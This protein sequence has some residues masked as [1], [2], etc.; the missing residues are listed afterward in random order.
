MLKLTSAN[1]P[2]LHPEY[3]HL[4]CYLIALAGSSVINRSPGLF[5]FIYRNT[6]LHTIMVSEAEC[7]QTWD[8]CSEN[9]MI[10][11]EKIFQATRL[12]EQPSRDF[13]K[14]HRSRHPEVFFK[15]A[16]RKNYE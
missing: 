7:K 12:E 14:D 11:L 1:L 10:L 3:L 15:K 8:V 6:L 4:Y 13:R 16:V 9:L 2:L 5:C